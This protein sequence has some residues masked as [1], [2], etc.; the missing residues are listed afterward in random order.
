MLGSHAQD[1]ANQVLS[2]VPSG[3]LG[4][5]LGGAVTGLLLQSLGFRIR[6]SR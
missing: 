3:F 1:S 4:G 2:V 5:M 6:A